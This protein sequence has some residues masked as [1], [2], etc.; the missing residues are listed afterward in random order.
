MGLKVACVSDDCVNTGDIAA[1]PTNWFNFEHTR[2]RF[3]EPVNSDDD[4]IV[5]GGGVLQT[6]EHAYKL[7]NQI[8]SARRCVVWAPGLQY[9][10]GEMRGQAPQWIHNMN[11]NS[12][13]CMVRIRDA[14]LG[15]PWLPCVSC[16][17][18][19]FD[20]LI[21]K[22]PEHSFVC[23]MGSEYFGLDINHRYLCCHQSLPQ[24]KVLEFLA[25]GETV[26]TSS[27][28]GL[29]W[30]CL[31]NRK[32]IAIPSQRNS[33]F[34]RLP[35]SYTISDTSNWQASI[36]TP[37]PTNGTELIHYCRDLQKTFC[38]KVMRFLDLDSPSFVEPTEID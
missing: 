22:E 15:I 19:D 37:T 24:S 5:S 16:M 29:Y 20:R 7:L 10:Y 33:K 18:S 31:L 36:N 6:E 23:Y 17:H 35:F 1:I 8:K 26:V 32:V 3:G 14:G 21:Q 28:H 11:R 34:F 12:S 13:R 25:S 38:C 2:V 9:P 30:A 27:Y 4:L